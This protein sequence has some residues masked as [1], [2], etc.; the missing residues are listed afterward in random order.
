MKVQRIE[1][2]FWVYECQIPFHEPLHTVFDRVYEVNLPFHIPFKKGIWNGFWQ[3]TER[4]KK[5][6]F[7]TLHFHI[8]L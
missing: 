3:F 8:P 7:Y 6:V 5:R 4:I 2:P 1:N